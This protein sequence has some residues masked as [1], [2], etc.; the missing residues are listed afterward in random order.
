MRKMS[1]IK[2]NSSLDN[3]LEDMMLYI[4]NN[5]VRNEPYMSYVSKRQLWF[6]E[7]LHFKKCT[8]NHLKA[9]LRANAGVRI[10]KDTEI[11]KKNRFY[12]YEALVKPWKALNNLTNKVFRHSILLKTLKGEHLEDVR[13]LLGKGYVRKDGTLDPE[14]TK[15]ISVYIL[16][17]ADSNFRKQQNDWLRVQPNWMRYQVARNL[18]THR[19]ILINQRRV[20]QKIVRDSQKLLKQ[21]EWQ[22]LDPAVDPE[23]LDWGE[24]EEDD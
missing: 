18:H 2:F 3:V 21:D 1:R 9:G 7:G 6:G 4:I 11:E 10:P 15:G 8:E 14:Q 19:D 17:L 23:E 22:D 13:V 16:F 24:E 12:G 20:G 5:E